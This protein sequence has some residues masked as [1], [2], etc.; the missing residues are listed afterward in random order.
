MLTGH[1]SGIK[2]IIRI[3][4][5]EIISGE[6]RGDLMIWDIVQGVCIRTIILVG[7]ND[8]YQMK[9]HMG[10][11]VLGYLQKV[12]VWGAAN[13]WIAPLKQFEACL[14]YLIEFSEGL[15]IR[16]GWKGLEFIDYV[17]TACYLPQPIYQLHSGAILAMQRI[18]K[19]IV[20]TT[21]DDGSL[22]VIDPIYRNC[23]LNFKEGDHW[24]KA[25]AYFY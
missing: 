12:I 25:I 23:Y 4:N 18:A 21:S 5:T 2:G 17:Q 10:E 8:L 7:N 24:M 15:L 14:G 1:T 13:K 19:N 22:K 3:N 11:V 9:Q 6:F 16:G 20:V